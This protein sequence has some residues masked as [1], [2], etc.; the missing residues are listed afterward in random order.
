MAGNPCRTIMPSRTKH[1]PAEGSPYQPYY[2]ANIKSLL[3]NSAAGGSAG[4]GALP[5]PAIGIYCGPGASHSWLWFVD[6]LE[7]MGFLN[8][9]FI[10]EREIQAGGLSRYD[11]LLISGGDTFAIAGALGEAGARELTRF[12]R[13]GGI[14]I[15]SCAGAYLPLNSSLFPLNLF[16]YVSAKIS[17]LAR[18]LPAPAVLPEKF[19]TPYGCRYVFHPVREEVIM[20]IIDFPS[21]IQQYTEVTAP[22]Y[23]GPA[24]LTPGDA[25]TVALY[26]GFTPQ[27]LY[28]ADPQLAHDTLVGRAA[29]IAKPVGAGT[30]YLSGPHLEHPR[31]PPANT[32]IAEMLYG[33]GKEH[34]DT[35]AC[36]R[37]EGETCSSGTRDR[38]LRNIRSELSNSRI[39]ALA[40]ERTPL[41]WQIGRKVYEPEKISLFLEAMWS[42]WDIFVSQ[43]SGHEH[44]LYAIYDLAKEVTRLVRCIQQSTA[45]GT[46][47]PAAAEELFER[48]KVLTASFLTIYCDV[49]KSRIIHGGAT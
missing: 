30:M 33:S 10:N 5:Y 44:E 29:I 1:T 21:R 9:A 41:Q 12:L 46:D 28:L 34:G 17:N 35:A 43:K 32:L 19:C 4:S 49:R 13:G 38:L 42:R 14:Y 8:I 22:L 24:F 47:D 23:G 48:L 11:A 3:R 37:P 39:A 26:R 20:H 15:G 16:N 40:L 18:N 6:M 7:A 36:T 25:R 45:S 2:S 31:Y 27:T